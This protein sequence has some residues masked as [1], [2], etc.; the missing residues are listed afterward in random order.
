MTG[1][2]TADLSPKERNFL[3]TAESAEKLKKIH[4]IEREKKKGRV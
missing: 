4:A 2:S 3:K 1:R